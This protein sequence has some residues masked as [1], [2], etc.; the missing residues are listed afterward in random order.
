M[1]KIHFL[2]GGIGFASVYL[3]YRSIAVSVIGAVVFTAFSLMDK[4]TIKTERDI[5]ITNRFLDFLI[6]L[7]PLLKSSHTFS[8]S[9]TE[10]VSDYV[11]IHGKDLIYVLLQNA[12]REFGMNSSTSVVLK[13]M[14]VGMDI[15]DAYLFAGSISACEET[16]GNIVE[17]TKKT[18]DLLSGKIYIKRDINVIV[19][20]KK[21]EQKIISA[22][23]F[24][25]LLIFS[26][27]SHSYLE[28]MYETTAGRLAMSAAGFLF[29]AEWYLSKKITEIRV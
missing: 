29:L 16:G 8:H 25:L 20:G 1:N 28:P 4:K 15:E 13:K 26:L 9:F 23:P 10:A 19:S 21:F 22:M 2:R 12:A 11:K 6:C 3:M 7:E 18:S 17:V 24:L 5:I 14:A 27:S